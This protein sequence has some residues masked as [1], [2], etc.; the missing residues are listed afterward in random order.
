[1]LEAVR[2]AV[3]AIRAE[4]TERIGAWQQAAVEL[5]VTIATRV[6][7]ERVRPAPSRSTTRCAT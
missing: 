3:D 6:L 5:A 4:R 1:V 2:A 7:H